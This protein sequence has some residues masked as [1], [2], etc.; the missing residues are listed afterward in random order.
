MCRPHTP[1]PSKPR[2]PPAPYFVRINLKL[3]AVHLRAKLGRNATPADAR[4]WLV[5]S[6]HHGA[7]Q[8]YITGAS[9]S[10]YGEYDFASPFRATAI[11]EL[12][13]CDADP[14]TL[15]EPSEILAV[16][17]MRTE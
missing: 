11:F 8:N 14:V 1:V 16:W 15:L 3:L 12:F 2:T 6:V 7:T 5:R 9:R 10:A 13:E 4:E 17:E